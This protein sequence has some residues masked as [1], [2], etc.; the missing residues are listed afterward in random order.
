MGGELWEM[1]GKKLGGGS[2]RREGGGGNGEVEAGKEGGWGEE[3]GVLGAGE[4][5][6]GSGGVVE[7]S[8]FSSSESPWINSERIFP[9][10]SL[11]PLRVGKPLSFKW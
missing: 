4:G 7:I 5:D 2:G 6:K 1:G 11:F 9:F 8:F 10:A 3:K